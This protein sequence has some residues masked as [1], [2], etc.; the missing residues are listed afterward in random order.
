MFCNYM[1]NTIF[2]SLIDYDGYMKDNTLSNIDDK[3][4]LYDVNLKDEFYGIKEFKPEF[5]MKEL[6]NNHKLFKRNFFNKQNIILSGRPCSTSL[7]NHY[8]KFCESSGR[9]YIATKNDIDNISDRISDNI[10]ISM[11]MIKDQFSQKC[12]YKNINNDEK[13]LSNRTNMVCKSKTTQNFNASS[14][15]ID[16]EDW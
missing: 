15:R 12:P 5:D 4:I 14:K 11:N 9:P 3:N 10:D 2:N 1:N 8:N 13:N 7:S 16:T 6:I